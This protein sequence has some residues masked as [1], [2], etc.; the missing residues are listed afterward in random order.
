MLEYLTK[1]CREAR[2]G[3]LDSLKAYKAHVLR[4]AFTQPSPS[5]LA[6]RREFYGLA[7][8]GLILVLRLQASVCD[9]K[10]LSL[11]AE[12]LSAAQI[13]FEMQDQP[14]PQHSWLFSGHELGVAQLAVETSEQFTEDVSAQSWKDQR[15]A[16][17]RRYMLWSGSLRAF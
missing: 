12:V 11:E 16:M 15:L 8:E 17:R 2:L 13:I 9:A 14:L 6:L 1:R 10:R 3:Y 5:E 7:H 4:T